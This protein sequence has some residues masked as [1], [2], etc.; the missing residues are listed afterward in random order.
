MG[1]AH[2][3]SSSK[4][5][6]LED[7]PKQVRNERRVSGE[8]TTNA[9]GACADMH[10]DM[11]IGIDRDANVDDDYLVADK[12][13][14]EA[15][16]E[17]VNKEQVVETNTSLGETAATSNVEEMA[18]VVQQ[19]V[20][21]A[22]TNQVSTAE[23]ATDEEVAKRVDEA[24]IANFM[25]EKRIDKVSEFETDEQVK[26]RLEEE[27]KKRAHGQQMQAFIDADE[28]LQAKIE[29]LYNDETVNADD[30]VQRLADLI[31]ARYEEL[32]LNE[33]IKSM[34]QGQSQ[35]RKRN[36]TRRQL[37]SEMK[38]YIQHQS[39]Y[40]ASDLRGM[41]Y[42]EIERLYYRIKR[43]VENFIP[44]GTEETPSKKKKI[45]EDKPAEKKN[46]SQRKEDSS[47]HDQ[48][49]VI[50]PQSTLYV[51]PI[52]ARHP[53]MDWEIYRD[54]FGKAWKIIR[55]GGGS[56]VYKRFVDLI[57]SLD[58]EDL[59]RLWELVQERIKTVKK[60]DAKEQDLWVELHRLYKPD[61]A[62]IYWNFPCQ[63]F[64]T[65]WKFYDSCNVHQLSTQGGVDVF[66]LAEKEY[67][68]AVSLLAVMISTK[69][70]CEERSEVVRELIE[71]IHAQYKR[72]LL[73][74]Q[75][76]N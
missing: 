71:R 4:A 41:E 18:K 34:K 67:P 42:E 64:S 25:D 28:V 13:G 35:K 26:F 57:R 17:D 15:V 12:G 3:V 74:K 14:Y 52:Q 8:E 10:V 19:D 76:D 36:P 43:Y 29:E 32:T 56:A 63:H 16:L 62:D 69:I 54:K 55:A 49:M 20:S 51:D 50:V 6:S 68:L 48:M 75:A 5:T 11:D 31:S 30:R 44:M 40:K 27:E 61:P 70:I 22:T 60:L 45:I 47:S 21:V 37:M 39:Q 73:R 59:D 46:D 9:E 2:R 53:I 1:T 24:V 38:I 7:A 72:E 65:S 58:R 23:V 33:L 66:M